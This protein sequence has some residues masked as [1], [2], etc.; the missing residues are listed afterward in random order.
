MDDRHVNTIETFL[1][2]L[3]HSEAFSSNPEQKRRCPFGKCYEHEFE[4]HP[5]LIF[6]I[7]EEH[8]EEVKKYAESVDFILK[9]PV[10]NINM[11][12]WWTDLIGHPSESM[13]CAFCGEYLADQNIH[14][15]MR[16]LRHNQEFEAV[17]EMLK[18]YGKNE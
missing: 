12:Y 8:P 9:N 18:E 3:F 5:E 10:D 15:H 17:S 16:V 4:S 2:N 11:S 13:S 7:M 14:Q 1:E 6:H